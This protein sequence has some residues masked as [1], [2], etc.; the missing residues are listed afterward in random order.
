MAVS[1]NL[2]N[3]TLAEYKN[4][5]KEASKV[6]SQGQGCDYNDYK[7]NEKLII[8]TATKSA[9]K[10]LFRHSEEVVQA[11]SLSWEDLANIIHL[12]SHETH[13]SNDEKTVRECA[14]LT[15]RFFNKPIKISERHNVDDWVSN[16][17]TRVQMI[18]PEIEFSNS[19][20]CM[21]SPVG[22]RAALQM[23]DPAS[24]GL[25]ITH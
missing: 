21:K 1:L 25:Y 2:D 22:F 12:G 10:I 16:L 20:F 14:A 5:W 9:L 15:N 18:E 3:Q 11:N 4:S 13:R 8:L 17:N 6:L 7:N 24:K 23:R 19:F